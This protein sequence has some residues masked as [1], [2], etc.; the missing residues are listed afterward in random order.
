M[1]TAGENITHCIEP[2]TQTGYACGPNIRFIQYIV[3]TL[4]VFLVKT[5]CTIYL[6]NQATTSYSGTRAKLL[7]PGVPSPNTPSP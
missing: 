2:L 3:T 1:K 7:E 5:L 4:K 6:R